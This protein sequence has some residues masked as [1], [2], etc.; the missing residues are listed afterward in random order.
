MVPG[1]GLAV[2][3]FWFPFPLTIPSL[4]DDPFSSVFQLND[5]DDFLFHR[6]DEQDS[7]P[8]S[9]SSVF[10]CFFLF[11]PFL[12]A[13]MSH[14]TPLTSTVI[15]LQKCHVRYL[16]IFLFS[17]CHR[18]FLSNIFSFSLFFSLL[19]SFIKDRETMM[20]L[21]HRQRSAEP[22]WCTCAIFL[23]WVSVNVW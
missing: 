13:M 19:F 20:T 1:L 14:R 16:S 5:I 9:L 17:F 3:L 12:F 8:P 2:H 22:E 11:P 10:L 15:F 4:N 21:Q 6:A 18:F 7:L 23:H